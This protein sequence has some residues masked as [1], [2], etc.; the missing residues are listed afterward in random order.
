MKY[1]TTGLIAALCGVLVACA[2]NRPVERAA[3]DL[4]GVDP[5]PGARPPSMA[6]RLELRTAAWFDTTDMN[7]RLLYDAPM[8][9]RQFAESRWAAKA[10]LLVGERLQALFGP[11]A[12][13]AKC[14]ARVELS[15]FA[16]HF[17]APTK[18]RFVLDAQ[19]SVSSAGGERL[20]AGVRTFSVD[21]ASADAT[22]GVKAAAQ[23]TGQLG[24]AIL[25]GA[26]ALSEC[27]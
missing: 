9:L 15:E 2:G 13:G 12:P 20:L 17:D 7:Y 18:S 16:Q 11:V 8:R 6:I 5:T 19:W 3:Y 23:A 14:I 24:V 27:K 4:H 22:G 10:G 21:A 25:A 1:R 26:H